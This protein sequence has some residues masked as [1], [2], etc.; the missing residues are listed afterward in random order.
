MMYSVYHIGIS[1]ELNTGYIGITKNTVERFSQ[2]G[3]KRKKSNRH[4]QFA[5]KKYGDQVFKRVLLSNLD[6]ELAELCEEMLRPEPE[7][8]WN[9]VKG[10]GV[11]PSPKGKVRSAE[12]CANIA[13]AK[14]G[15]KN[16]MFGKKIIFSETHRARLSEASKNRKNTKLIGV[17]RKVV[18]CPHCHKLGG[19]GPMQLWH[20]DRCRNASI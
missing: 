12:H 20:F 9:I 19:V 10:G 13:K 5:F 18:E 1:P 15:N 11:P 8:G 3:W 2:H 4:L 7:I 17:K 14:T 16:P 6:K